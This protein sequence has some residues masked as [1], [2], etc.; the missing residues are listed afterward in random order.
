MPISNQRGVAML[1]V[2]IFSAVLLVVGSLLAYKVMTS[3][4]TSGEQ[5]VKTAT[6]YSANAGIE[7]AR[8][9]LSD[10]YEGATKWGNVLTLNS[11]GVYP[12][13]PLLNEAVGGQTVRVYVRDNND[14]PGGNYLLDN[15]LKVFVLAEGEGPDGTKT[16]VEALVFLDPTAGGGGGY[17]SQLGDGAARTGQAASGLADPAGAAVSNSALQ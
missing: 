5:G 2:V 7:R 15:D 11:A 6:Y 3:T 4:R 13:A 10:S 16:M 14:D 9:V 12:T 1:T 17:S 8:R